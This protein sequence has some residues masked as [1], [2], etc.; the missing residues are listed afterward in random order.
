MSQETNFDSL[1][2]FLRCVVNREVLDGI[3]FENCYFLECLINGASVF[4]ESFFGNSLAV[5]EEILQSGSTSG[6][7]LLFTCACGIADDGGWNL[8]LVDHDELSVHWKVRRGTYSRNY[9]FSKVCYL[10]EI[11]R[12][13]LQADGIEFLGG[14]IEPVTIV[15][16]EE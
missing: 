8:S 4:N 9:I 11:Q 3:S 7:F 13:R 2:L 6:K 14:I 10:K 16:P 5:F 12:L 15:P 1:E